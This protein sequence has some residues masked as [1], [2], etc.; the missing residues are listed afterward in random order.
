VSRIFPFSENSLFPGRR[1]AVLISDI[2]KA[3]AMPF[4]P[5][6]LAADWR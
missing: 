5:P 4:Y 6:M 2:E 3:L 1:Q